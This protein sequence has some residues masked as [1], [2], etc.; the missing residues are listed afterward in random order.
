MFGEDFG[1]ATIEEYVSYMDQYRLSP[2]I[3]SDPGTFKIPLYV[4]DSEV[5]QEHFSDHYNITGNS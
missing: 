3:N 1:Y 5:L 2:L 4:F